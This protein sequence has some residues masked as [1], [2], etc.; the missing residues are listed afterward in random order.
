MPSF[1]PIFDC[2]WV[3]C[4]NLY[5]LNSMTKIQYWFDH[6]KCELFI[7]NIF[8]WKQY[9]T[10]TTALNFKILT[11]IEHWTAADQKKYIFYFQKV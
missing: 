8:I 11:F 6:M 4:A 5:V 2:E 3:F 7:F 9:Y 1:N 10:A